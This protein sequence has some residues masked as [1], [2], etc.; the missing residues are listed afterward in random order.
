MMSQACSTSL[1]VGGTSTLTACPP[2][3]AFAV[4]AMR[5]SSSAILAAPRSTPTQRLMY[6]TSTSIALL[7]RSGNTASNDCHSLGTP[8]LPQEV[9]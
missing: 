1:R 4:S 8:R 6:V 3:T 5:L 7:V 9:R 2:P